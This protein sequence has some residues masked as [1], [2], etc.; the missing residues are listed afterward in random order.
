MS[1]QI[2]EEFISDLRHRADIVEVIADYVLLKKQGQNYTG[3]CPF[4]SE[5]TP[6]FVVSPQK[7]IYHCF[8]CGKGGNVFSFLIEKNGLSF[9]DAINQLAQR[10][11]IAMPEADISPEKARQD[12]LRKRYYH[13]NDIAAEYFRDQLN[14][15]NGQGALQYLN[16]RGLE[17]DTVNKFLLGYAPPG[18]DHLSCFLLDKEVSEQEIILMGLAVRTKKGT[19]VDRFRERL[20]YPITDSMGHIVGFGGRVLDD[21]QPKYLNS[22]DTP[23]FAKG[24]QL[25]ALHW[26][27]GS[28]RSK[29]QAIIMEGYMDV[30]TAH[31]NGITNAVGALG[32][33]LTSDQVR[34][35]MRSTY[36][37]FICFDADTAGQKATLRGL[38]VLQQQGCHVSVV[39]IPGSKDPDEFIRK[40]GKE[41]FAKLLNSAKSLLEYR[42]EALIEEHNIQSVAGKIQVIQALLPDIKIMQSPVARQ[43]FIQLIGERLTIPETVVHAEIRKSM[44]GLEINNADNRSSSTS[45]SALD[46]AQKI[47]IRLGLDSPEIL[48]EIEKWGGKELFCHNTLKE[49][50][51]SIGLMRQAGHNIKANDLI[52]LLDNA[53][54]QELLTELL[55]EENVFEDGKRVLKDCL[56]LLKLDHINHQIIEKSALMS[57]CEKNGEASKSKEIMAQIQ[58]LV[59]DKQSLGQNPMEGGIYFEN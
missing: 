4:H 17:Q 40:E 45:G 13:I 24:R 22:P 26:A 32:T 5:K 14:A 11:G 8:G 28:I 19:L 34:L 55:L 2:P 29:D 58:G 12:S 49:I 10:Y 15:K 53:K 39:A 16:K 54:A 50:Y 59:K 25:Y 56:V 31:Q 44:R 51:D 38:D 6:S 18:W 37:A 7:Q 36:N 30:I 52:S 21:A 41:A 35:L 43:T 23:V 57:Q 27:K 48:A 47:L 46:K 9:P 42:I 1:L 33:A 20:M 3:L